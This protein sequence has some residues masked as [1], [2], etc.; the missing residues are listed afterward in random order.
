MKSILTAGNFVTI[1]LFISST[2]IANP[3]SLEQIQRE[4]AQCQYNE[5]DNK[6]QVQCFEE[7]IEHNNA[8]LKAAPEIQSLRMA[9]DK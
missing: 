4:W 9:C 2:A 3:S 1:W 8:E 7:T 6:Q 5:Q